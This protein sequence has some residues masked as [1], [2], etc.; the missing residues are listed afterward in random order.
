MG[1]GAMSWAMNPAERKTPAPIMLAATSPIPER[2]PSFLLAGGGTAAWYM[3]SMST[4]CLRAASLAAVVTLLPSLA[5]GQSAPPQPPAPPPAAAGA[6]D[7]PVDFSEA[8]KALYRLVACTG[9]ALP[10]GLD[11]KTV[12]G[13]CARQ[14]KAIE[15]ARKHAVEAGSFIGKQEPAGLPTTVVYPFGGGDLLNALT[16]YPNARDVT[17]LS[18]EHAGDPRRPPDLSNQQ[19]LAESLE[20]IRATASGLLNANDSKTENL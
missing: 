16:V 1:P 2:T 8:A 13:Y 19:K 4:S 5:C 10:P 14:G 12:A 3:A 15:A 18:L 7:A 6:A 20:L 9:D 11:A 17:T